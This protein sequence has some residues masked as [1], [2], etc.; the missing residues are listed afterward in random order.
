MY[1]GTGIDD[2]DKRVL[3]ST[4]PCRQSMLNVVGC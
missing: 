4:V 3:V 2:I 1:Y